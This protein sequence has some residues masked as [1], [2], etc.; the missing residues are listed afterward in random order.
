[1]FSRV[2]NDSS[3]V[4]MTWTVL[5]L[6]QTKGFITVS[7]IFGPLVNNGHQKRQTAGESA[8]GCSQSQCQVP[9]DQGRVRITELDSQQDYFITI[10]PRNEE[11]EEGIPVTVGIAAIEQSSSELIPTKYT[12][13]M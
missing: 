2:A 9:Y 1:M 6:D 13:G 4:L 7:I 11:S 12:H 5:Q 3:S 8:L 10:T